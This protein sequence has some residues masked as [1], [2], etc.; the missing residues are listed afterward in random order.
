MYN[1]R[2]IDYT[3]N[4]VVV[5]HDSIRSDP[6]LS[7]INPSKRNKIIHFFTYT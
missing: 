3:N 1:G 5:Y 4:F 2:P 6:I 7:T